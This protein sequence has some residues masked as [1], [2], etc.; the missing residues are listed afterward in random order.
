MLFENCFASFVLVCRALW[1][2]HALLQAAITGLS[3]AIESRDVTTLENALRGAEGKGLSGHANYTAASR[4]LQE[5]RD[6][7]SRTKQV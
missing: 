4:L 1:C 5:L 2:N 3:S 7:A 6:V